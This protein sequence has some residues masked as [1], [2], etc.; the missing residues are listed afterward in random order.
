LFAVLLA[1]SALLAADVPGGDDWKYEVV[2]RKKGAPFRGLIVD[3]AATH[4][5]I[6]CISRKPGSPTL[7][8][9]EYLPRQEIDRIERLPPEDREQL[10]HRLDGLKR[11]RE[12]LAAQLRLLEPGARPQAQVEIL[13]LRPA[14]WVVDPKVPA[15]AYSSTHFRLVSNA[16]PELVQLAAI[17]LEQIYAAYTR[18]L[19]PRSRSASPTT[20]LLTQSQADYQALARA[21]G[22]N[23]LNPAF[24]HPTRNEIVC[25]SDL[26]RLADDLERARRHHAKLRAELKERKA[27]LVKAYRGKVPPEVLGP[28]V[29]VEKRI[30][31]AE[32]RN[33]ETFRQARLRLFQRLYHEA[34]HAYL[35][36]Y[37]Y[38]KA[39]GPAPVWLNEGLAQ[40]FETA[41]VEVGE[42][43]VGHA[44]RERL[45]VLRRTLGKD[46]L[47]PL[48]DLL[49]SSSE[50]FRV[51]HVIDRQ[52]SDRYYLASWAL[53]FYLTFERKLLGTQELDDYVH[54]LHRGADPLAAFSHLV[55]Q[56]LPEF[57]KE[58]L[59]YLLHLRPNGTTAR[60]GG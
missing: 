55:G 6:K 27:D 16:R 32:E 18:F 23:L 53:S 12:M 22:Q 49:R 17:H 51:A 5:C 34:F 19:P 15:L 4:L 20:I 33:D 13:E 31:G 48:A 14:R 3:E 26:E 38:P 40:I 37:V 10:R 52:V 21:H 39:E 43:R 28:I 35:A 54:A 58:L 56:P 47:L 50:Q 25:G 59:Q 2:Y 1:A 9:T 24:Y 44:D 29:D 41:I 36:N 60:K 11:E 57:E 8:F 30:K 45:E 46:G 42:L 7:V